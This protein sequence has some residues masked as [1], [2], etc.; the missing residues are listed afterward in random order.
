MKQ[1]LHQVVTDDKFQLAPHIKEGAARMNRTCKKG[2]LLLFVVCFSALLSIQARA[3]GPSPTYLLTEQELD[4]LLAPIA[5]YP[6]PLLAQMLPASTYPNEVA[7]A[8]AWLNSGGD[9]SSIDEQN[10]DESVKA[11]AHYPDI[12]NMMGENMEWTADLG[13]AFLN[14]PEDVT[15]SIQ[16]LRWRARAVGNLV[17]TN[18]QMV[19]IEGDYIRI[20]PVQPQYLYVPQYDPSIVY[21]QEP[22]PGFSP[23]ITFG[24]GLAIG[25]WLSMD[26][27]WNQHHVIYHGWDRPGWVNN[28]RPYIHITNVYINRS[29]PYINRTW[30]HDASKG[31]PDR[32]R[33]SR[34]S[35]RDAG[36]YE[37]TAEVRG[38]TT[39][40]S[41][42]SGGMFGPRGDVSSFSNRGRESRGIVAERPTAPAP[43]SNRRPEPPAPD[44]SQRSTIRTQGI[45]Q[46]PVPP[47]PG[48]SNGSRQTSADREKLQP[49]RTPSVT[50]GGYRGADEARAQSLR[51]QASRQSSAG[52]RPSAAPSSRGGAPASRNASGDRQRR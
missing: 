17:S 43:S 25:D 35:G 21:V 39:M 8:E 12:L 38:Q 49:V 14:Q 26:F 40:P 45:T 18:E 30:R 5:L 50:F 28:A 47:T 4:D 48:S 15:N 36:R 11:I 13:D 6:D 31:D 7:D 22:A 19:V 44:I 3:S 37:R 46:R 10:W 27:D 29:R 1:E 42:T 23:F 34:P 9:M 16:R 24:F 41:R 20:I 52:A 33:V 2:F 51:G 32:Y